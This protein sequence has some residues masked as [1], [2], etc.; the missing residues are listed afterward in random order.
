MPLLLLL[1]LPPFFLPP[2]QLPARRRRR[3]ICEY[4]PSFFGKEGGGDKKEV[5]VR[6]AKKGGRKAL[7]L[8]RRE[9]ERKEIDTEWQQGGPTGEEGKINFKGSF[10]GSPRAA[11]FVCLGERPKL[12]ETADVGE[13]LKPKAP[14]VC[15]LEGGSYP[16]IGA[17][18]VP[19]VSYRS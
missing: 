14:V 15:R 7:L 1:L 2:I 5:N 10:R 18:C 16:S 8:Q 9:K 17:T 3:Q 19:T 6:V 13:S 11:A 12:D 4:P